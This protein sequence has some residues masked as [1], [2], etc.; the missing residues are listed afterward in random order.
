MNLIG[1]KH[2]RGCSVAVLA[3]LL[4]VT[5]D[6]A[7]AIGELHGVRSRGTSRVALHRALTANGFTMR[8]GEMKSPGPGFAEVRLPKE[9]KYRWH[10]VAVNNIGQVLDPWE[11]QIFPTLESYLI[12]QSGYMINLVQVT[13]P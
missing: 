12:C 4:G 2:K 1:Q 5:Y 13:T 7:R 10:T 11:P 8:P 6:E 9:K 3:M